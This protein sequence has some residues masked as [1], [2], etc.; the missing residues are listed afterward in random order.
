MY[1]V[2]NENWMKQDRL[3][4]FRHKLILTTWGISS[5]RLPG[6]KNR[7]GQEQWGKGSRLKRLP[8]EDVKKQMGRE[9]R[10]EQRAKGEW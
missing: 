9:L 7:Q 5:H 8:E 3:V 1:S 6:I 10:T 4:H 2:L